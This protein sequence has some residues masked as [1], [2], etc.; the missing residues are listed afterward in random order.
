MSIPGR[1]AARADR[2]PTTPAASAAIAPLKNCR[3][4]GR[5]R[6][7][8][9]RISLWWPYFR[10]VIRP[11]PGVL[12][13]R[14][15]DLFF[16]TRGRVRPPSTIFLGRFF[17]T[18]CEPIRGD[19]PTGTERGSI[20]PETPPFA[21]EPHFSSRVHEVGLWDRTVSRGLDLGDRSDR[22]SSVGDRS[23][24]FDRIRLHS[25]EG[26]GRPWCR[27]RHARSR[28]T[29]AGSAIAAARTTRPAVVRML[30]PVGRTEELGRSMVRF[31]PDDRSRPNGHGGATECNSAFTASHATQW[32]SW[33][34][35]RIQPGRAGHPASTNP[36]RGQSTAIRRPV[37]ESVT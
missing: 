20:D 19:D 7:F 33:V 29:A 24:A 31:R 34:C 6:G 15:C 16:E 17:V 27:R 3:R 36:G 4:A 11:P 30:R 14:P 26:C 8:D 10:S 22:S 25:A 2:P 12:S 32:T 21:V 28:H 37:P 18:M 13:D 9:A 35:S 1:D 23:E 5:S